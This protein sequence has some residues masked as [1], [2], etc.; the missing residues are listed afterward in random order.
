MAYRDL[1][2]LTVKPEIDTIGTDVAAVVEALREHHSELVRFLTNVQIPQGGQLEQSLR[3]G[4]IDCCCGGVY[5]C[6]F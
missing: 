1:R 6:S 4:T 3:Y 5:G 2:T